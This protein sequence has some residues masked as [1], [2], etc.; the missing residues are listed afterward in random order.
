MKRLNFLEK[1]LFLF[2]SISVFAL[3]ITYVTPFVNPVNFASFGL[4]SI[5][6]PI[7]LI[8]NIVFAVVWLIKLKPH[9]LL[10]TI[11]IIIGFNHLLAFISFN[12]KE[13]IKNSKAIKLISYNVRQFNRYHWIKSDSLE[14]NISDFLNK[15]EAD[16]ICFQEYRTNRILDLNLPYKYINTTK[17]SGLAIYS[18][19]PILNSGSINFE[20]SSNNIIFVDIKINKKKTRVYNTHL[21][22]FSVDFNKDYSTKNKLSLLYNRMKS[23]FTKQSVQ[24]NKLKNHIQKSPYKNIVTGDFNSTAF[25]W[26]Y[27]QI[28]ENLKDAF[29][30]KGSGLGKSFNFFFPFR[31]DYIFTDKNME[32]IQYKTFKVNLSD[33]YPIMA[34]IITNN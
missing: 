23:V 20:H 11:T 28:S 2:N 29:V 26:N 5:I 16:I 27:R 7:L 33:H 3:L 4:L 12:K 14:E 15:K 32:V 22:S 24:I 25:S 31:I 10:S 19:Y 9:F 18:K 8:L 30:E 13:D 6:Y 1:F 17:S 34:K 21:Q